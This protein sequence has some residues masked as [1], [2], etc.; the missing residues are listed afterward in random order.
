MRAY[1]EDRSQALAS[2]IQARLAAGLSR[3]DGQTVLEWVLIAVAVSVA[4]FIAYKALG[5][6]ISAWLERLKGLVD[7]SDPT[8]S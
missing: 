3:R 1:I 8:D 5:G 6:S 7:G 2:A 4:A